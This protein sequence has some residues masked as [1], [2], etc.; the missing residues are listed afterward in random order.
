MKSYSRVLEI[1][2]VVCLVSGIVS[3]WTQAVWTPQVTNTSTNLHRVAWSGNQLVAAS[4]YNF[5]LMTSPEGTLWTARETGGS[6]GAG[7]GFTSVDW[8][9]LQFVAITWADQDFLASPDGVTWTERFPPHPETKNYSLYG[10]AWTGPVS[11]A[12]GGLMVA[13]GETGDVLTSPD[14]ITWTERVSGTTED[15][16]AV[17]WNGSRLVATGHSGIVI[18]SPDAINWTTQSSGSPN[19]LNDVI[20]AGDRFV[21]VGQGGTVL[22]SP[23]GITWTSQ[24]IGTGGDLKSVTWSGSQLATVGGNDTVYTSANG[25][26]WAGWPTGQSSYLHAIVWAGNK[27]VAVGDG[28]TVLTSPAVVSLAPEKGKSTWASIDLKIRAGS[29]FVATE[30]SYK[31]QILSTQGRVIQAFQGEGSGEYTLPELNKG[32]L[33][34]LRV[35]GSRGKQVTAFIPL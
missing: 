5:L 22:T 15:L 4:F 24:T 19:D 27:F 34:L 33:Y 13:V 30:G 31:V 1:F 10:V 18:T 20:W 8:V 32:N 29:F 12:T 3:G 2:G 21:A 28:G 14:G 9:G 7:A 11:S 17:A 16:H 25:T 26:V 35:S 6:G 23:N